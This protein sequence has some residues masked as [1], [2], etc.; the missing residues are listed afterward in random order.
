M[1]IRDSFDSG[2]HLNYKLL[3]SRSYFTAS[4]NGATRLPDKRCSRKVY[5]WFSG[6]G[7]IMATSNRYEVRSNTFFIIGKTFQPFKTLSLP[8][9][10]LFWHK[11]VS[12]VCVHAERILGKLRWVLYFSQA[13]LWL[14]FSSNFRNFLTDTIYSAQLLLIKKSCWCGRDPL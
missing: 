11:V 14:E 1:K 3:I 12:V 8:N 2:I 10:H 9:S 7:F 4:Q 6:T 5:E 13:E